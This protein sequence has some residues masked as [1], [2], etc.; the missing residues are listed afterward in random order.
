MSVVRLRALKR[1]L[2]GKAVSGDRHSR[3]D[4][5]LHRHAQA[6]IELLSRRGLS[7]VTRS[8]ARRD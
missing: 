5:D 4:S 8:R 2:G 1:F 3:I 7:I 6:V